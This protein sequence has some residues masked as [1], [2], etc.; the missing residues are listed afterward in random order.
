MAKKR[1][2]YNNKPIRVNGMYFRSNLEYERWSELRLLERAK[3]ISNLERQV[4]FVVFDGFELKG[5]RI[6]PIKYIADFTYVRDGKFIV[7]DAKGVE[8]DVFKIKAKLF[9]ARYGQEI[10]V[11]KRGR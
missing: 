6:R 4:E 11:Y 10:E 7:E 1:S 2:K 3:K 9:R 5:K 8:T